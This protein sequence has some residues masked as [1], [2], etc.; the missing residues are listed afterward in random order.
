MLHLLW[1]SNPADHGT[2]PSAMQHSLCV[3]ACLYVTCAYCLSYANSSC[4]SCVCFGLGCALGMLLFGN[5]LPMGHHSFSSRSVWGASP[6]MSVFC[7]IQ[8]RMCVCQCL[9]CLSI[10]ALCAWLTSPCVNCCVKKNCRADRSSDLFLNECV[11]CLCK[12]GSWL[13]W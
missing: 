5:L 4:E 6:Q 11:L 13:H 8:V 1:R 7:T 12:L 3:S 10:Y 9:G 2:D